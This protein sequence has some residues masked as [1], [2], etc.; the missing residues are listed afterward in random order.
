MSGGTLN[1][2]LFSAAE[3]EKATADAAEIQHEA[4]KFLVW[5]QTPEG[6]SWAAQQLQEATEIAEKFQRECTAGEYALS[7]DE[8]EQLLAEGQLRKGNVTP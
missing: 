5:L 2:P 7:P 8:I 6:K 1:E 4:D 3:L